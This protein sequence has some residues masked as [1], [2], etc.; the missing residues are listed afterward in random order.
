[1]HMQVRI[2][3]MKLGWGRSLNFAKKGFLF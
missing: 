2:D 1:M 3:V